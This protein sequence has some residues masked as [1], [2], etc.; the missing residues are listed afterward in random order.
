MVE[1]NT[2]EVKAIAELE[3]GGNGWAPQWSLTNLH[4]SAPD[5]EVDTSRACRD[6]LPSNWVDVAEDALTS[7]AGEDY[8]GHE[9]PSRPDPRDYLYGED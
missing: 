7:K 4:I 9:P 8:S 3:P 1:D 2:Y 6:M 5:G